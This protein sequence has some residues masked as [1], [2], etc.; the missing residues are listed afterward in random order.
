MNAH[1]EYDTPPVEPYDDHHRDP[2][3]AH[4][5]ERQEQ[6]DARGQLNAELGKQLD[7]LGQLIARHRAHIVELRRGVMYSIEYIRLSPGNHK[8]M[9]ERLEQLLTETRG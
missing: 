1:R 3:E 5:R 2:D 6:A 9:L 7:D 4:D 8:P